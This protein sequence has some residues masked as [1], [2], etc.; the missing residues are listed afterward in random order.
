MNG[1]GS[2]PVEEEGPADGDVPLDG[3]GHGRKAGA[4]ESDL[5]E[6]NACV[7]QGRAYP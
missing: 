5:W 7:N 4:G 2:S 3:E 1:F 6:N